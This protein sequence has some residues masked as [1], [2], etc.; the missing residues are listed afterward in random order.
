MLDPVS[1]WAGDRL[2]MVNHLRAE[3]TLFRGQAGLLSLS[4]LFV[5]RLE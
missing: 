4:P 2:W 1:A 3:P 5:V